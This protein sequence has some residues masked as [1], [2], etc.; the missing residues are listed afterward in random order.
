MLVEEFRETA[1]EAWPTLEEAEDEVADALA[2]GKVALVAADPTDGEPLGWIG[3]QPHYSGNVWEVHPLVVRGAQQRRG[4]G[5]FL[6]SE[7]EREVS[8]RGGVTLWVG[9]DDEANLTSLGGADVY[10]NVLERLA[11][12]ENLRGHPMGFYQKL[13]FGLVGIVP[14]ANGFGKPDLLMARRVGG[15]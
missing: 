11:R 9:T 12:I 7:V 4:V 3:A 1:P 2:E 10:P 8:G 13:G 5:R 6:V 14:D 15:G